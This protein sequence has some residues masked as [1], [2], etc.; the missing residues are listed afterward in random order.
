MAYQ[1]VGQVLA[2]Y[3]APYINGNAAGLAFA[4]AFLVGLY[5]GLVERDGKG[6]DDNFVTSELAESATQIVVHRLVPV[7]LQAREIGSS[8]NGAAYNQNQNFTTTE[9]VGIDILQLLDEP[10]LIPRWTKD[11][12]P[13][14]VLGKHIQIFSD[15]VATVLNGVTF[16]SKFLATYTA[17]AGVGEY[18]SAQEIRETAFDLEN[19]ADKVILKKF[20][21][22]NGKLDEGDESHDIDTFDRKT[23]I[24]VIKTSFGPW[25][26]AEGIIN[27]GGANELYRIIKNGGL[28]GDGT[29][30]EDDGYVGEIDG[31]EVREISNIALKYAATFLG[32]PENE[33]LNGPVLGYIAS[34][35][36]N[37]R[38]VTTSKQTEVVPEVNGQGS[39]ILPY[40]AF[41]AKCWYQ[42]GNSFLVEDNVDIYGNLKTLFTGKTIS[43]KLK[44]AGS[45]LYPTLGTITFASTTSASLTATAYDDHET[46]HCVGAYYVVTDAP[47][48]TVSAFIKAA[49][50]VSANAGSV[51]VSGGEA[52]VT[53]GTAITNNKYLNILAIADD[54]SCSLTSKKYSS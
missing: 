10:I 46:D 50:A 7:K 51:T 26:K 31:V 22:A 36:A 23:R 32:F 21:K 11:H 39:R 47:V 45:R 15:R 44:G 33:I 38:G 4:P 19:D 43:F 14:D 48:K 30:I 1:T 34:S 3:K 24:C 12:L 6:V 13:V 52:S 49:T 28:N 54:G 5:Q 9:S 37:A 41:G 2:S 20:I 29:R 8:K 18:S 42:L 25:L 35:Y 53:I 17:K 27:L 40:V 16:A